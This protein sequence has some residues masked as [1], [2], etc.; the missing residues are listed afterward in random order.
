MLLSIARPAESDS[1]WSLKGCDYSK[2][3]VRG[4]A[5]GRGLQQ[6]PEAVLAPSLAKVAK[7][8][9]SVGCDDHILRLD[10][11]VDDPSLVQEREGL[12]HWFRNL[13]VDTC[14]TVP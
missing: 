12:E 3:P 13:Q 4:C 11:S 9:D 1:N 10:V 14:D 7:L 5:G 8:R 6:R 2:A